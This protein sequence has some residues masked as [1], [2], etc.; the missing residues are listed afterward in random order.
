MRE[1]GPTVR[2]RRRLVDGGVI[3]ESVGCCSG[4][5]DADTGDG[6][7]DVETGGSSGCDDMLTVLTDGLSIADARLC[8]ASFRERTI[9]QSL[10]M[11]NMY[12]VGTNK[13]IELM[14][15]SSDTSCSTHHHR[16]C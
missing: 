3:A 12:A 10:M 4:S 2:G 15:S 1:G 13:E 5:G 16:S 7:D 8:K 6:L 11:S 14:V 9:L